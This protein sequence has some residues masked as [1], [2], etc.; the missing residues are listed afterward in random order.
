MALGFWQWQRSDS[1]SP[2]GNKRDSSS[3]GV[4]SFSTNLSTREDSITNIQVEVDPNLFDEERTTED[5]NAVATVNKNVVGIDDGKAVAIV[6]ENAVVIINENTVA[7]VNENLD[8]NDDSDGGLNKKIINKLKGVEKMTWFQQWKQWRWWTKG[9]TAST[10]KAEELKPIITK[11]EV[12]D[13]KSLIRSSKSVKEISPHWDTFTYNCAN[14]NDEEVEMGN[15][16]GL[17]CQTCYQP[18]ST[19]LIATNKAFVTKDRKMK[20]IQEQLLRNK[21]VGMNLGRCSGSMWHVLLIK[22]L[23]FFFYFK[24]LSRAEPSS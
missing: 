10:K 5:E 12:E 1:N 9:G 8:A 11:Q 4:S 3:D 22:L 18:T 16:F 20:E 23:F 13:Q 17:I 21:L 7:T 15:P 24:T 6:D 2:N 14:V 19:K